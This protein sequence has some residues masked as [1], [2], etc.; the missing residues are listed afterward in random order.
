VCENPYLACL[1]TLQ[2]IIRYE[3]DASII[4]SDILVIP[5]ALGMEVTMEEKKGKILTL[6]ANLN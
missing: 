5:R 2:P 1:V 3:L 6:I 4:F